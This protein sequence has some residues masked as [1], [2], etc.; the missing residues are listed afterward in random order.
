MHKNIC[1]HRTLGVGVWCYVCIAHARTKQNYNFVPIGDNAP[2]V[3]LFKPIT[4]YGAICAGSIASM[5]K[6]GKTILNKF[7]MG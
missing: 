3:I 5:A 4:C 6:I 7:L 1:L 2:N